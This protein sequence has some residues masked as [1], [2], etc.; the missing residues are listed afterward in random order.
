MGEHALSSGEL[1]GSCVPA[2]V[3]LLPGVVA[4][5]LED[6][7]VVEI[8]SPQLWSAHRSTHWCERHTLLNWPICASGTHSPSL[9]DR[10]HELVGCGHRSVSSAS[11]THW[12]VLGQPTSGET[13]P[14]S[15]SG[16]MVTLSAHAPDAHR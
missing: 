15:G 3:H 16:H 7:V 13:H 2:V 11:A 1:T 8:C 10:K 6:V 14:V 9:H 4:E 12:P 5:M